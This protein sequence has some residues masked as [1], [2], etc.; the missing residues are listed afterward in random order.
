[1]STDH[2][3]STELAVTEVRAFN[4]FYTNVIGVLRGGHLGTSYSLTEARVLFELARRDATEVAELRR[5]LD[6]DAGYLSR[7]L[8]R[9]DAERLTARERSAS[10]G[11]RQVIR[12]TGAGRD[13]FAELDARQTA[14]TSALLAGLA[15]R[16]Q[17]RLLTAMRAIQEVLPG[18]EPDAAPPARPRSYLLR[19][20]RP[21]DLGWVVQRHGALY[22][23]EYDFD[24]TF[25]FLVARIVA[26]Y[27][28]SHDPQRE[29]AWIAEVDGRPAGS[30]FCVRQD[31]ETAKLRL[32]LVEPSTRGM[33]IGARLV[34]ECLR[35]ARAAG[36]RQMTLWT[37]DILVEAIRIYQRAGFELVAEGKH[38]SFGQDLVD[39]TWSRPL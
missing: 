38:H 16:D 10:D 25:E 37:Q 1:M 28:E 27:A 2:D 35:F 13:A 15:E 33:G 17:A 21:G 30:V 31:D 26:D 8:A 36:Y 4:R 32:L 9:F 20:P 19:A 7:I 3:V 22:A 39:Q 11:R 29:A 14:Q 6:I 24:E 18:P 34:E 12:L 23:A 5:S